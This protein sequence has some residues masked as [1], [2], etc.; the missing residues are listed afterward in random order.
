VVVLDGGG[1]PGLAQEALAGGDRLVR[2]GE[3]D[4]Q[5]DLAAQVEVFR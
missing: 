5:G 1:G 4:L 2:S 3:H